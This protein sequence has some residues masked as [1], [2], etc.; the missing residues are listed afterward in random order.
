MILYKA[1][2][3]ALAKVAEKDGHPARMAAQV[4]SELSTTPKPRHGCL[5][6][7][8]ARHQWTDMDPIID[9]AYLS[10]RTNMTAVTYDYIK[11]WVRK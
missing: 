2:N 11:V 5:P 8:R 4:S 3:D 6:Q 10:V 9:G 1:T 7:R